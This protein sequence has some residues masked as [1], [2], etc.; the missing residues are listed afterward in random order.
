[1]I[2]V[3]TVTVYHQ[4]LFII[5]NRQWLKIAFIINFSRFSD[6]LEIFRTYRSI[7]S[8]FQKKYYKQQLANSQNIIYYGFCY[9]CQ[10]W[11]SFDN[12]HIDAVFWEHV[13]G[14]FFSLSFT[15]YTI[16]VLGVILYNV[17]IFTN[18]PFKNADAVSPYITTIIFMKPYICSVPCLS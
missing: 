15:H 12:S 1:M 17:C 18:L 6:V 11:G 4:I 7:L 13:R 14:I 3:L 8:I 2:W 16:L 5:R 9:T 10:H